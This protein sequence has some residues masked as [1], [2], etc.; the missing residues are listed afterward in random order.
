MKHKE[1]WNHKK[2]SMWPTF[3]QEYYSCVLLIIT[4]WNNLIQ[5]E[6]SPYVNLKTVFKNAYFQ[7]SA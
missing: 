7:N 1:P 5:L 6:T 3:L 4:A 2:Q